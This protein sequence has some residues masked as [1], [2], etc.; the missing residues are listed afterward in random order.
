MNQPAE[1]ATTYA[2]G[3][4]GV[5]LYCRSVGDAARPAILFVHGWASSLNAWSRQYTGELVD[6][7][8]LAAFDVRG[9]GYSGRPIGDEHYTNASLFARDVAS[10]IH[11]LHLERPILV[12]WS[13]GSLIVADYLREYGSKR[14]AGIVLV[15]GLYGLGIDLPDNMLGAGPARYMPDTMKEEFQVQSAAMRACSEDMFAEPDPEDVEQLLAISMMTPPSVRS[16]MMMRK[17]DNRD[18]FGDYSGPAWVVHGASDPFILPPMAEALCGCLGDA[19][20]S[21]YD[22]AAHMPFWEDAA[23]FNSELAAFAHN[24]FA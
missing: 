4:G 6:T 19:T 15:D 23:R 13:S 3:G 1:I 17:C 2:V 12:G 20:L 22:S 8:R 11:A 16:S 21:L 24:A 14:V 9:H 18:V 5:P 10:V 7:Y